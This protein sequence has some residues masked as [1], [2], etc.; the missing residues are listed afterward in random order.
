VY[1]PDDAGRRSN[2]RA[3]WQRHDWP[4]VI[5]AER[6]PDHLDRVHRIG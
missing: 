4:D 2:R 1:A 6:F 3:C 5:D